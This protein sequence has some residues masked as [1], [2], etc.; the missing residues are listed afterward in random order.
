M[1]TP[2]LS[3]LLRLQQ[4]IAEAAAKFVVV[5]VPASKNA[6]HDGINMADLAAVHEF[7]GTIEIP[8]RSQQVYRKVDKNGDFANGGRFVRKKSANF[9]SYGTIPAYTIDMPERSFLRSSMK[10]GRS[11]LEDTAQKVMRKA[12]TGEISMDAALSLIAAK[13]EAMVKSTLDAG[14]FAPLSQETIRRKGSSKPLTDKGQ[15]LQSIIG[16]VRDA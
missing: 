10:E 16:E 5:G 9:A 8:A 15:L 14:N 1:S 4:V 3:S 6:D 7:G 11:D 2:D 12:I 13:S